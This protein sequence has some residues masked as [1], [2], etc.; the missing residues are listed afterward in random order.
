M[1]NESAELFANRSAETT[2]ILHEY[3]IPPTQFNAFLRRLREIIPRHD[4]DLLNVTIRNIL[5]DDDAFLRYADQDLF[6]LVMLFNQSR[7][8]EGEAQM[9]EMTR[10]LVAAVLELGGRYYLPYRLHATQRQFEQAYPQAAEFFE[11]KRR[12]DPDEL[13]QNQFY[14]RY[15]KP[16]SGSPRVRPSAG[17]PDLESP[18][19]IAE[20]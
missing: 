14:V 12:Y 8:P 2:D 16:K 4:G 17:I 6:A 18:A 15:G 10:D 11:L 1:L 7:L 20:E 3:F 19:A 5:R 9:M 13:F